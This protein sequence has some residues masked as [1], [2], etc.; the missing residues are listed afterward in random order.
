VRDDRFRRAR[1]AERADETIGV[2]RT[3]PENRMRPAKSS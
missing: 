1:D 3:R 2:E